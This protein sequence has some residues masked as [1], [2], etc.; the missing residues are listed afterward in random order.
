MMASWYSVHGCYCTA[1]CL[2]EEEQAGERSWKEK[3]REQKRREES[4]PEQRR[5]ARMD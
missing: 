2:R 4:Q 5:G 1:D 3:R